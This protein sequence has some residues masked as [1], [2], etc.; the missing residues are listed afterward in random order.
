ME[1]WRPTSSSAWREQRERQSEYVR[2]P[3]A[4]GDNCR[5]SVHFANG[6]PVHLRGIGELRHA[7]STISTVPWPLAL[8]RSGNSQGVPNPLPPARRSSQVE[9]KSSQVSPLDGTLPSSPPTPFHHFWQRTESRNTLFYTAPLPFP[10]RSSGSMA[11]LSRALLRASRPVSSLLSRQAPVLAVRSLRAAAPVQSSVPTVTTD[12]GT[13]GKRCHR[14]RCSI[15]G[16]YPGHLR[17]APRAGLS[18][19][20]RACLPESDRSLASRHRPQSPSTSL[21]TLIHLPITW[22][23]CATL[24]PP[25]VRSTTR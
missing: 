23:R 24:T 8:H 6:Y 21:S 15:A 18:H 20:N 16:R 3:C 9:V 19:G 2:W 12:N 22:R 11:T 10:T 14:R 25:T 13:V 5:V 7:A 1:R 17:C 4:H